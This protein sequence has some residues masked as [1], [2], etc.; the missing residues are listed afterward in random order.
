MKVFGK[1]IGILGVALF[2]VCWTGYYAVA[3]DLLSLD[4]SVSTSGATN[5]E[6]FKIG[7][8]NYLAVANSYNGSTGHI[9]SEILKFHAETGFF[10]SIQ[11]PIL[12]HKAQDLE[13]FKIEGQTSR[14]FGHMLTLTVNFPM[15]NATWIVAPIRH[16]F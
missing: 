1:T 12:T 11:Q 5:F 6:S 9:N 15:F 16:R 8:D 13:S 14:I 2:F 3:E 10:E 4:Q 7:D